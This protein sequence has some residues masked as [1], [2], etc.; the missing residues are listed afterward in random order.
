MEDNSSS[1]NASI[2][3][4]DIW[5]AVQA[6]G[7]NINAIDSK[8]S[9]ELGDLREEVKG[10]AVSVS[11]QVKRIKTEHS[12]KWKYEGNK[13][14]YTFNTELGEDF[15][16]VNWALE[17]S[18][19]SYA[20]EIICALKD[21]VSRRNKLIKI[22]DS[23]E[24]GWETVRQYESNPIASDS[25]DEG[26]INRAENR[27]I[28][29]KKSKAANSKRQISGRSSV[30]NGG[31]HSSGPLQQPFRG[32]SVQEWFAGPPF[33]TGTLDYTHGGDSN[34][35]H[36]IPVDPSTIGGVSVRTTK[37]RTPQQQHLPGQNHSDEAK[38][39]KDKY[40]SENCH[41]SDKLSE[42]TEDYYEYEQGQAKII[43]RGRLRNSIR[44]WEYIGSSD[45]IIETLKLGYKIPFYLF[46]PRLPRL[47]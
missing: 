7:K 31:N 27:A 3:L 19:H 10:A 24:G 9:Q 12:Y 38:F 28:K 36:A 13:V 44:F 29:K 39:V 32:P 22:A 17:N 25:E 18:K 35:E 4:A 21:K 30:G 16:Q 45:F 46:I 5:D 15:D 11:S 40:T 1:R 41:L 2:S 42:Y 20:S 34:T 8:L 47:F 6:Q 23:S 33:F 14:Q 26:K 43:V 37:D